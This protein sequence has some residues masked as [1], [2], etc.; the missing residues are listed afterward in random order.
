[1]NAHNFTKWITEKLIPNLHEPSI[2]VFDNAPYH[3]V[4]TNK[5]STSSSRIEEIKN[6]LIENNVEFDPR[7]RKP[8]LLTLVK[9]HK[10]QPIYEID[11]LLVCE[12]DY[13]ERGRTLYKDIDDLII[14]VES[15][16]SSDNDIHLK[17]SDDDHFSDIQ[18]LNFNSLDSE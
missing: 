3:S 6:W 4:I 10:P 9:Q 13:F 11:E 2:I 12:K 7:L 5:A 18:Y 17:D 14:Q 1:M 16:T 15:D 8:N